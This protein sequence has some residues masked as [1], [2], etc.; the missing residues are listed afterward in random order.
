MTKDTFI[1]TLLSFVKKT[2]YITK[3]HSNEYSSGADFINTFFNFFIEFVSFY[4][5]KIYDCFRA[6][7][8]VDF[9][10]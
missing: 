10:I 9:R 1:S 8:P 2:S 4:F 5:R 7:R 6:A 3:I